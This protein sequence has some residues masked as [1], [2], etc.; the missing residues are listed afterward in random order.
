MDL[1]KFSKLSHHGADFDNVSASLLKQKVETQLL[2]SLYQ[3]T[4]IALLASL[5]CAIFIFIGLWNVTTPFGLYAWALLFLIISALRLILS[6]IYLKNKTSQTH[7]VTW[8]YLFVLGAFLAA[9]SWAIVGTILFPTTPAEQMLVLLIFAGVTAGAVPI[10]SPSIIAVLVF[11]VT[12]L[13]PTII[14]LFLL[15]HTVP[16]LFDMAAT[17][18]LIYLI[19]VSFKTHGIIRKSFMLRFENEGLLQKL[20]GAKEEL[21]IINF[22]L[23]DAATHDPLTQLANRSLFNKTFEISLKRAQA[24]N[25]KLALFYIDLDNF[26]NVNDCYGHDVGDEVLVIIVNRLKSYL[27]NN[28]ISRLGGDE[29]TIIIEDTKFDEIKKMAKEVCNI[30]AAPIINDRFR[31]TIHAS[32]G[33]SV[34]PHDGKDMEILLK[35]ADKNMY[36]IKE[37][38]GNN[39]YISA[40]VTGC[41]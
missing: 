22:K 25:K 26:K 34:F 29:L 7:Y 2:T 35:A 6:E 18:Y 8:H 36:Y 15:V 12:M 20:T 16:L 5:M 27:K 24:Q 40:E 37:R 17:V 30:I 14:N 1:K 21:E 19:V 28:T 11:V 3:Q 38:G 23:E 41:R 9:L 4:K 32:M 13:V 10:L 33:I 39:F 31:V